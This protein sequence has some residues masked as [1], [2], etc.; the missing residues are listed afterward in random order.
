M[1]MAPMGRRASLVT[2]MLAAVL[3]QSGRLWY[4]QAERARLSSHYA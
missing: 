3:P 4:Y 1:A 2:M